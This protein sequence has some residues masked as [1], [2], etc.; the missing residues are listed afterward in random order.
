[1]IDGIRRRPAH[2]WVVSI[3][4]AAGLLMGLWGIPS[5]NAQ[6]ADRPLRGVESA[7]PLRLSLDQAVEQ[8]LETGEE[9]RLVRE[10]ILQAEE[11]I[12]Q[13]RSGAFP[14]VSTNLTYTRQIRSIFDDLATMPGMTPGNG[15]GNGDDENPFANLPFGRPN[16]WIASLSINQTLYAQGQVTI[17]LDIAERVRTLLARELDETEAEIRAE[18]QQAYFQ[19]VFSDRLVEISTEAWELADRQLEEVRSFQERGL[20]S[21]FD[22]LTARVERDNLRPGIVEAENTRR[23]ARQNLRRLVNLPRDGEL[24]LT[25]ALEAELS[26]VDRRAL[27]EAVLGRPALQAAAEQI[28]IQEDQV[29]LARAGFR[30]S[31]SAFADIGYQAFPTSVFPGSDWREDW[32]VGVQVSIPLF[33]GF[34][35]TAE[36]ESA[37]SQVRTSQLERQRLEEGLLLE[38]DGALA[39]FDG[40]LA[41]VEAR[42][43]TVEQATRALELAELRFAAGSATAL[44]VSNARL[45]LQQ[46]RL[47]E[48]EGLLGYVQAL[49]RLERVTGGEV[50]LL[51]TR[52]QAV[53]EN[54]MDSDP[55][56]G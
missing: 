13:V 18:V 44:E 41:D 33:T 9:V 28:R 47:N 56:D 51:T 39:E 50:P 49:S 40:V 14:Q 30:P 48:A 1:M 22:V 37:R 46:A 29:R 24:E 20:A 45:N 2:R 25:T 4:A 5:A 26:D 15:M 10:Q 36:V 27:E 7:D 23:L 53:G 35:R 3:F 11:E 32:N 55:R 19:A 38:F 31:A 12:T 54:H 34:R 42:R 43:G 21:E 52:I 8:A 16:T 17:G 6:E